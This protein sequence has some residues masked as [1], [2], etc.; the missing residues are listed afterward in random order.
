ML[1]FFFGFLLSNLVGILSFKLRKKKTH[2]KYTRKLI[3]ICRTRV[4][5]RPCSSFDFVLFF[6]ASLA[7]SSLVVT[8]N[9]M[10]NRGEGKRGEDSE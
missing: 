6:L 10:D 5:V 8:K 4:V 7:E 2:A 1:V 3:C 9:G